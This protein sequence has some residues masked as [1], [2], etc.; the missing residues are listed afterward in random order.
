MSWVTMKK[1]L[2]CFKK[3]FQTLPAKKIRPFSER[4][5]LHV[6]EPHIIAV[7]L[8]GDITLLGDIGPIGIVGGEF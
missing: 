7:V 4:A 3:A 8:E 6:A 1:G 2:E 5:Y